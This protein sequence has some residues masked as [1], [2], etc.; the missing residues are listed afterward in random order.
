MPDTT[1]LGASLAPAD[2]ERALS[3]WV[4]HDL[5]QAIDARDREAIE[6]TDAPRSLVLG[7]LATTSASRDSYTACARLGRVLAENGGSPSLS[8]V[9]VDGAAYALR[10]LGAS[11][12]STTI[13]AARASVAEGYVAAVLEAERAA[14]Q[15]Q[16]EYPGCAVRIA[17]D[18]VAISAGYPAD[19]GEALANWA[20]R[21]ALCVSR[22][23]YKQACVA[24][25][26]AAH[27]ELCGALALVG[28]KLASAATRK[29][30]VSLLFR[31]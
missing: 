19:D 31:R 12:D 27:A 6:A 22:D 11:F 14:G 3:A 30:W 23:G 26:S 15:R 13:R 29:G 9:T 8:A 4:D 24:G 7:L 21:V 2:L 1:P 5:A 18:T 20:A 28:V 16:W 17:N 10:K 25:S